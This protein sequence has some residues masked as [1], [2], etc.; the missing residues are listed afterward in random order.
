M[1]I[2]VY[3]SSCQ[4]L[5]PC[6]GQMAETLG[7]WIGSHGH[8]LVYGGVSAGLMHTVAAAARH[9]GA[10][11][12]GVV[13]ECF[14]ARADVA[15][16]TVVPCHDLTDRKQRMIALGHIFVCLPGGLGTI[17]EWIS[18]L[19]QLIV[20][21]EQES[22]HI[23]VLNYGGMFT[24]LAEQLRQCARSPFAR[25]RRVDCSIIVDDVPQLISTLNTLSDNQQ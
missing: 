25:S 5:D 4:G 16:T 18:T 2:V 22:R 24:P 3:C 6:Y 12:L 11:V 17:D 20:S 9:A 23:V 10:E 1:N 21:G 15:C 14:A 8:T 19:S 7:Q 13:P